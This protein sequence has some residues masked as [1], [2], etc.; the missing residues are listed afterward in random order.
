MDARSKRA[1][2]R[3]APDWPKEVLKYFIRRCWTFQNLILPL[4]LYVPPNSGGLITALS[5]ETNKSIILSID[6][7]V[8]IYL[9]H[10]SNLSI[11]S[12]LSYPILS[13]YLSCPILFYPILS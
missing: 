10:L 6:L 5:K 12:M 8:Y 11:L 7:S 4:L 2:K 1:A 9:F 3:R 13:I